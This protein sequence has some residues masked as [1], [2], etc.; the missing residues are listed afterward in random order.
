MDLLNIQHLEDL[1]AKQ[2][3]YT[4]YKTIILMEYLKILISHT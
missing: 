4:F 3:K 2:S 1:L